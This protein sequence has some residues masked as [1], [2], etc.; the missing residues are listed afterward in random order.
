MYLLLYAFSTKC[1][2]KLF[3]E[4]IRFVNAVPLL[5]KEVYLSHAGLW[6]A[7]QHRENETRQWEQLLQARVLL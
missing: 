6:R 4:H 7:Y 2:F 1:D 5:V 3:L